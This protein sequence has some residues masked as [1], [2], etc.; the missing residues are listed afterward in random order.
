MEKSSKYAGEE[1][2]NNPITNI[3]RILMRGFRNYD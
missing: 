1:K 3:L 2:E